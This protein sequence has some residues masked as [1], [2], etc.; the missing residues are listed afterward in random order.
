MPA[1]VAIG[2]IKRPLIR[3]GAVLHARDAVT[4]PLGAQTFV[5]RW[6]TLQDRDGLA[7]H[8]HLHADLVAVLHG[9]LVGRVFAD[10]VQVEVG[11][12]GHGHH[13]RAGPSRT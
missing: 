2:P 10:L 7:P 5:P 11:N 13:V 3:L 4:G 6:A 9:D 1:A 12:G 8:V